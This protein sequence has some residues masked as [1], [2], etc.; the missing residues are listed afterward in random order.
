[1]VHL[2][3]RGDHDCVRITAESH[4]ANYHCTQPMGVIFDGPISDLHGML[5]LWRRRDEFQA[6]VALTEGVN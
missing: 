1:M 4:G 3:A 2:Y 5:E 6:F